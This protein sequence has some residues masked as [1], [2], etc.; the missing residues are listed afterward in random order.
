MRKVES[1]CLC[2]PVQVG[3][4]I[5]GIMELLG[6]IGELQHFN[7][8]TTVAHGAVAIAF[9]LMI[10]NDGEDKRKWFFYAYTGSV[11]VMTFLAILVLAGVIGGGT[12]V[13]IDLIAEKTCKG[14]SG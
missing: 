7:P 6:L 10:Y 9:I 14:M 1:C 8:V 2:I 4:Y 12:A 13:D 3:A 5:L 11:I